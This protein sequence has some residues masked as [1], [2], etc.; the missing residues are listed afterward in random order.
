MTG[1]H[2]AM[3]N[4]HSARTGGLRLVS[5][6]PSSFSILKFENKKGWNPLRIP[7][8]WCALKAFGYFAPKLIFAVTPTYR[9]AS[10]GMM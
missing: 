7:A 1:A 2:I 9:S 4:T 6:H 5:H 3:F 10:R 8:F